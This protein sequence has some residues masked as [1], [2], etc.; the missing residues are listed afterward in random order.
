[1]DFSK[2]VGTF[3]FAWARKNFSVG[4]QEKICGH[5]VRDMSVCAFWRDRYVYADN[6]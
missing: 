4:T 6:I 3:I 1:M 5:A 2:A